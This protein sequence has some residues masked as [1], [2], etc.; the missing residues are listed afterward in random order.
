MN[1][2]QNVMLQ[3]SASLATTGSG[4]TLFDAVRKSVM[5]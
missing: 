1:T 2:E 5:D 3:T 4:Q